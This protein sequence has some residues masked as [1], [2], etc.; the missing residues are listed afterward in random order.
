MKKIEIPSAVIHEIRPTDYVS[1]FN[2]KIDYAVRVESGDHRPYARTK[3]RQSPPES[4]WCVGFSADHG[5]DFNINAIIDIAIKENK[6]TDE[7]VKFFKDNGYLDDFGNFN[8]SDA[9][10]AIMAGITKLGAR[11]QDVIDSI[12]KNG[13]IPESKLPFGKFKTWEEMNDKTRVTQEMREMGLKFLK[14]V[15]ISY[16]WVK[17]Y[18]D[19][20]NTM[21]VLKYHLKQAP[22]QITAPVC[23]GWNNEVPKT[24]QM[25]IPQHAT[26][27]LYVDDDYYHILDQYE[28]FFKKLPKDYPVLYGLK[29]VTE[30][31]EAFSFKRTMFFLE[32]SDDVGKMQEILMRLGLLNIP[33]PTKYYGSLTRTAVTNFQK[34]Y[35]MITN[36]GVTAGPLTRAKLNELLINNK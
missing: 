34:K 28:P 1:G 33:K 31:C 3:E 6:F 30:P 9:F 15:K 18:G 14:Y 8:S 13:L 20:S 19:G 36:Y 2:S 4:Y 27:C 10:T 21:E 25:N 16:E 17:L 11:Q 24:C 5:I 12:R 7:A 22:I 26:L 23:P 32:T 35:G 29:I